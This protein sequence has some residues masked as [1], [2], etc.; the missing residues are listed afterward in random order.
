[1]SERIVSTLRLIFV[2][3]CSEQV[4]KKTSASWITFKRGFMTSTNTVML[5]RISTLSFLIANERASSKKS[6][7]KFLAHSSLSLKSYEANTEWDCRKEKL[8]CVSQYLIT[9]SIVTHQNFSTNISFNRANFAL[10][11][12]IYHNVL[13][14]YSRTILGTKL[15]CLH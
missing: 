8:T 5:L 6:E 1:M 9:F 12:C 4:S 2:S 13:S 7:S 14:V 3:L 10:Q 11:N 15:D